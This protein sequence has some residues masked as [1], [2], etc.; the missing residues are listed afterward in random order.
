MAYFGLCLNCCRYI[1]NTLY[2]TITKKTNPLTWFLFVCF[3]VVASP[4]VPT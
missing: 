3:V 4:D 2:E 1:I